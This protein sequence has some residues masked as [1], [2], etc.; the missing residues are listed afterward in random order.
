V[1]D[2]GREATS[3]RPRNYAAFSGFLSPFNGGAS[4]LLSVRNWNPRC[5]ILGSEGRWRF[6]LLHLSYVISTLLLSLKPI[7]VG[8]VRESRS[9]NDGLRCRRRL[10]RM[11][12]RL[13]SPKV[14]TF[15]RMY[16]EVEQRNGRIARNY[17]ESYGTI[18]H[19]IEWEAIKRIE[20]VHLDLYVLF[21]HKSLPIFFYTDVSNI[22]FIDSLAIFLH[23]GLQCETEKFHQ[24]KK[25]K[26]KQLYSQLKKYS[27][28]WSENYWYTTAIEYFKTGHIQNFLNDKDYVERKKTICTICFW[29][30][31]SLLETAFFPILLLIFFNLI[32][33][34]K[35]IF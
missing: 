21:V 11:R 34:T 28:I 13:F 18:S 22:F 17:Q 27:V 15:I 19:R 8:G 5:S 10:K 32:I 1:K 14:D 30:F 6:A 9:T 29:I 2:N 23:T 16:D 25:K 3:R 35:I 4:T 31:C 24:I 12:N 7:S 33:K 26:K 20:K